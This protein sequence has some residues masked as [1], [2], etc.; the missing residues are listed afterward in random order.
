MMKIEKR[1]M[2][3]WPKIGLP[4]PVFVRFSRLY[5]VDTITVS[6]ILRVCARESS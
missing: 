2:G 3:L 5:H 4:K 6:T 1:T